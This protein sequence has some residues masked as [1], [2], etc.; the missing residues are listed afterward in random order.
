MT[1]AALAMM[2]P[3][4][5]AQDALPDYELSRMPV[6]ERPH[7]EFDPIGYR[8]GSI[9]FYPALTA[10]V[11]YDSNVFATPD[12]KQSDFAAIVSPQLTI[13]NRAPRFTA[14]SRPKFEYEL[15]LGA[16]IYRFRRLDSE[17]RVDARANL[18]TNWEIAHDLTFAGNFLIA[19]RHDERGDSAQP[20]NAAEPVPYTDMRAEGTVTK[21][22][23][24]LGIEFN[25]SARRLDYEDVLSISGAPLTQSARNGTIFTTYVKP[26]YEFSPGYRAFA[27]FRAN[28]RDYEAVGALDRDSDGYD[29]R[30]G[31]EFVLTPLIFGS[32]EVGYLSQTY[33]N[34]LI[35]PFDGLSFA[36]KGKWLVT[37]LV[38]VSFGAERGVAETITPEFDARLDTIYSA[39]IDY[40]F[41][42]NVIAYAGAKHRH[43]E[44]RGT[45]RIDDIVQFSAGVDYLMNRHLRVGLR[46]DYQ[47][48]DSTIPV[49]NFD[50]HMVTINAKAQY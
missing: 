50:R 22:L 18:K 27:R 47:D 39:Q 33:N 45:P 9:F 42:R 14:V 48:R 41:L 17:D 1:F 32:V 11:R 35:A 5:S 4:A 15:D 8:M 26:F 44:F 29:V 20:L 10:G 19:R 21:N 13:T 24:R 28:T 25:A 2:T 36:A 37:P 7:P 49:F 16:D 23:D 43:E 38:T 34:P 40:E 30:G 3:D 31:L 6:R 12:N 46:Y